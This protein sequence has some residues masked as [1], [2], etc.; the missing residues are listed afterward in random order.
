MKPQLINRSIVQYQSFSMESHTYKNLLN[1]WH[2]HSKL[3]LVAILES[4][5]TRFIGDNIERFNPGEIVLM[6]KNLPHLWLHDKVGTQEDSDLKARNHVI[7]FRE[8][9]ADGFSKIPEMSFIKDLFN[10]ASRGI[11]FKG[12]SNKHNID[13]IEKINGLEGFDKVMALLN[14]LKD[15]SKQDDYK[16]LSSAGYVNSFQKN[17]DSKIMPVYEYIMNNF[18]DDVCL[19]R[20]AELANMNPSS[21]SRYFKRIHKK[22]FTKYVNEVKLGYAC[23]LLIEQTFNISEVCYRSG[24]N[25]VSNFNRQFKTHKNM[26]PTEFIKLHKEKG[27]LMNRN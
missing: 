12:D 23:K 16:L 20:A 17:K 18:T 11:C 3:E 5:G 9:F 8:D 22:T 6:G 21:F 1:I 25:N 24:F 14:V 27:R 19:D 2:Y 7:H 4:E 10:A 26:T 15:L 13:T